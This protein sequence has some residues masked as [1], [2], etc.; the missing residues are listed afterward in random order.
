MLLWPVQTP[1]TSGDVG[2]SPD[3]SAAADMAMSS[4]PPEQQQQQQGQVSASLEPLATSSKRRREL[5]ALAFLAG[6]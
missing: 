5:L 2:V 1:Q 3:C 6:S 4:A